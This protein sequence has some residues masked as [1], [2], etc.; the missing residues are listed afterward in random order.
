MKNKNK[1][2]IYQKQGKKPMLC[3]KKKLV[4]KYLKIRIGVPIVIVIMT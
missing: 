3:N 4:K 2:K 1:K